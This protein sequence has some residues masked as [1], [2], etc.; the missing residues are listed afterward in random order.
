MKTGELPSGRPRA[1]ETSRTSRLIPYHQNAPKIPRVRNGGIQSATGLR[2]VARAPSISTASSAC[3]L[4]SHGPWRNH[5]GMQL[6]SA[7]PHPD[8]G[9]RSAWA[10]AR[11]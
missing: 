7:R 8:G 3:H 10:Q 6:R 5:T 11:R 4:H 1:R 2:I 9:S